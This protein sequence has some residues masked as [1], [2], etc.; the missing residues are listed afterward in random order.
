MA[1]IQSKI[2]KNEIAKTL[3]DGGVNADDVKVFFSRGQKEKEPF[4]KFFQKQAEI[5]NSCKP[6]TAKIFIYFLQAS[7]YGNYVEADIKL[8]SG[9]VSLSPLS[10][11]RGIAELIE[12][13]VIIKYKDLNDKRRNSYY[14]N[15]FVSW[16]GNPSE[17]I[18]V[19]KHL[20]AQ[21]LLLF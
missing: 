6:A 3:T 11:K 18:K 14:I 5:I 7:Q 2:I 4:V 8:I 16:K 19:A 13:N 17:R 1:Q 21:P 15:P 12:K 10:V 9:I 20:E